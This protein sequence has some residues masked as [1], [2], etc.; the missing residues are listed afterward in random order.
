MESKELPVLFSKCYAIGDK[1]YLNVPYE[2]IPVLD[3]YAPDG[4]LNRGNHVY[5]YCTVSVLQQIIENKTLRFSDVRFLNDTTEFQDA[6]DLSIRILNNN[7]KGYPQEFVDLLTQKVVIDELKNYQQKYM[8][9]TDIKRYIECRVYS[10]SFSMDGDSKPMWDYYASDASGV[11]IELLNIEGTLE[12]KKCEFRFGS[13]LYNEK[14]KEQYINRMFDDLYEVFTKSVELGYDI[15][16]H[17]VH[18]YISA[19][20]N[21][22][23]F[24]KNKDYKE[25]N[26]FRAVLLVPESEFETATNMKKGFFLRENVLVPYINI[27][28]ESKSINLIVMNP[29][30]S[31]SDLEAMKLGIREILSQNDFRSRSICVSNIPARNYS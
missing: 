18:S 22:R 17:I 1:N 23:C 12:L 6:V 20:N 3:R 2:N 7:E 28:I 24:F 30:V 16:N 21:M 31:K 11:N 29:Y 4:D 14:E 25:E 26:E 9:D 15:E 8:Y 19:I 5:H 10:C 13:I 27:P